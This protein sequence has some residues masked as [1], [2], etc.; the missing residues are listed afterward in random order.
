MMYATVAWARVGKF[1]EIS[2][3]LAKTLLKGFIETW[4]ARNVLCVQQHRIKKTCR[5][6]ND[7]VY[8]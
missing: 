1:V 6:R 2:A 5:T 8:R 4:G 3:H 7:N